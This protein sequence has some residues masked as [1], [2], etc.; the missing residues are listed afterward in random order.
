MGFAFQKTGTEEKQM[1]GTIDRTRQDSTGVVDSR[2]DFS[3]ARLPLPKGVYILITVYDEEN[4]SPLHGRIVDM[5]LCGLGIDMPDHELGLGQEIQMVFHIP[6]IHLKIELPGR[7]TWNGHNRLGV[8]IQEERL[9]E[10]ERTSLMLYREQFLKFYYL[11]MLIHMG[12]EK[13]L[14]EALSAERREAL[15]RLG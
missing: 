5:G 15:R 10:S 1:Q 7:V 4:F 13:G 11:E 14:V 8:H 3:A 6:F 2:L 9:S 12:S